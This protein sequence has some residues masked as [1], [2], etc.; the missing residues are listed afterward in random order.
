M[1]LS[2]Q[3]AQLAGWA[4]GGGQSTRETDYTT[5]AG[6]VTPCHSTIVVARR[7]VLGRPVL[8]TKGERTPPVVVIFRLLLLLL[9]D[10]V[11][12]WREAGTA[13]Q[14]VAV[15]GGS[16]RTARLPGWGGVRG[17]APER[18]RICGRRV[19]VRVGRRLIG[20]SIGWWLVALARGLIALGV[21]PLGRL[22]VAA[23][24][25]SGAQRWAERASWKRKYQ[26]GEAKYM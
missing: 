1:L 12:V 10:W 14:W 3:I 23:P 19:G 5:H 25:L 7:R 4:G 18:V 6:K 9:W 8:S 16:A 15:R 2:R 11:I 26:R 21:H 20:V 24:V 17:A 22:V 13:G